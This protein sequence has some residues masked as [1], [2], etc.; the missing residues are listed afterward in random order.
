MAVVAL[1][2]FVKLDTSHHQKVQVHVQHAPEGIIAQ[3]L[4][5]QLRL[6]IAQL[7]NTQLMHQPCVQAV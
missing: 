6:A 2:H 1:V 4:V 3:L 7:E 5:Y